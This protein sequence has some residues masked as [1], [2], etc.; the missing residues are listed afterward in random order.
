MTD[1]NQR[2]LENDWV[3]VKRCRYGIM[4]YNVNDSFIG[5]SLDLYGEWCELELALLGQ[6]LRPGDTAVDVGA[7][8]GT[9]G[10]FFARTVGS[11]GTV[12]AI[13]PQRIAYQLLCANASLNALLNLRCHH[14]A[15]GAVAGQTVV[16]VLDPTA[17]QNFGALAAGQFDE[18][19]PVPVMTIDSLSLAK[20]R[21][22]KIDVEG[23][24]ATVLD[25][26]RETIETHRPALLVECNRP[27]TGP[28]SL[29][30]TITEMGCQAWWHIS[31]YF[32]P[33]NF[34]ANDDNQF[35][36]FAPEANLLF[37]PDNADAQIQGLVPV[38]GLDDDWRKAVA[39]ARVG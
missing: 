2:L 21:L 5:R 15:A 1:T 9:H 14:A 18:G 23:S 25:G 32:N 17:E 11:E 12:R 19:E 28:D 10:V 29:I 36:N 8:I 37:L 39:R 16:P 35:A 3:A 13:E 31:A 20:C 4:A 26:A 30:K 27:S 22:I 6:I 33:D 7:N 24:E 38:D 34:F